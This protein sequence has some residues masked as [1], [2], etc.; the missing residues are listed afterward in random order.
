MECCSRT[1]VGKATNY[2]CLLCRCRWKT[3][4]TDGG[5][6]IPQSKLV[7]R[8]IGNECG[9]FR[10]Q[11]AATSIPTAAVAWTSGT[12]ILFVVTFA[13]HRLSWFPWE[14]I[15]CAVSTPFEPKPW[16]LRLRHSKC[17]VDNAD[18]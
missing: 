4:D 18:L 3:S 14:W 7:S 8:H 11:C 2:E 16:V 5:Y 15:Q 9:Y 17:I 10:L 12:C 6:F 13:R 1:I